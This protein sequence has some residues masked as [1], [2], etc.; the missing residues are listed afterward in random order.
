MVVL[1]HL[2]IEVDPHHFSNFLP[3]NRS[4]GETDAFP[5]NWSFI[6][7]Q[8]DCYPVGWACKVKIKTVGTSDDVGLNMRRD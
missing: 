2:G 8:E 1:F 4:D 5:C 6:Q 7:G 3:V